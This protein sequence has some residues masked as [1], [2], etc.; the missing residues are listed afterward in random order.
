MTNWKNKYDQKSF[1]KKDN[2]INDEF[3]LF[4]NLSEVDLEVDVDSGWNKLNN[5]IAGTNNSSFSIYLKIAASIILFAG[6]GIYIF[7]SI[8]A[9][10]YSAEIAKTSNHTQQLML[11]DG[12]VVTLAPYSELYYSSQ[13][14]T[15][16]N[17]ILK[18][19]AFFEVTKSNIPFN[20]E[21]PNGEVSVLGTSF[22]MEDRGLIKVYVAEGK[23]EVKTKT[24][25]KQL[26]KGEQVISNK[27]G[28]LVHSKFSNENVFAWKSGNFNFNNE[29]LENII[30]YLEKHY[31]VTFDVK[32]SLL[33]CKLTI[34]LN[35]LTID[36]VSEIIATLLNAK[37]SISGNKV[38]ISGKGCN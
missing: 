6:L 27:Y 22:D 26:V 17:L 28:K 11:K 38:K 15:S 35:Q 16:R 34:E 37:S 14:T 2:F 19:E 7:L 4:I 10:K 12:S 9:E 29:S 18:G 25:N 8:N 36:E 23:V 30:P 5:K 31:S 20:I 33:S 13:F 1:N 32:K 21:S 24:D 3:D